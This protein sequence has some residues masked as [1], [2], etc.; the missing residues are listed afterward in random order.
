M[1][2]MMRL[3]KKVMME[4]RKAESVNTYQIHQLLSQNLNKR[5]KLNQLQK[6]LA[7]DN[8]LPLMMKMKMM[9]KKTERV[10]MIKV[11]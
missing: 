2:L 4:M 11:R 5:K 3:L 7:L 1:L 6:K 9:M 8:S 10:M